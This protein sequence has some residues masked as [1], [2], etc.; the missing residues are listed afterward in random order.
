MR[1]VVAG[2]TD[3]TQADQANNSIQTNNANIEI[4]GNMVM[5]VTQSKFV[6]KC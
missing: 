1:D 5:Q 2:L 6:I 4:Q 3:A